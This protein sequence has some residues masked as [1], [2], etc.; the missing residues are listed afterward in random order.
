MP[1]SSQNLSIRPGTADLH[2][3][4]PKSCCMSVED[5]SSSFPQ[6]TVTRS[7]LRWVLQGV[8]RK[9][10]D[11][12]HAR[13]FERKYL[14]FIS[15]LNS[16]QNLWCAYGI[17]TGTTLAAR[18]SHLAA[19]GGGGFCRRRPSHLGSLNP[20]LFII[21]TRIRQTFGLS[22]H[23][24]RKHVLKLEGSCRPNERALVSI[25]TSDALES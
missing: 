22:S 23:I 14:P 2:R 21:V 25:P 12:T 10:S 13:T 8:T 19:L 15:V 3:K 4:W 17:S 7:T 16:H 5:V 6:Q 20:L 18:P 1:T 11:A 9:L 24:A